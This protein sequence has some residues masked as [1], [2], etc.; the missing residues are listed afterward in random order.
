[1]ARRLPSLWYVRAFGK[2]ENIS[3][4]NKGGGAL[5]FDF[6]HSQISGIFV[7]GEVIIPDIA[8]AVAIDGSKRPLRI[9]LEALDLDGERKAIDGD[10]L[11]FS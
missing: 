1:M 7:G 4:A 10:A 8:G 6:L 9:S 3:A 5:S 11:T 2:P